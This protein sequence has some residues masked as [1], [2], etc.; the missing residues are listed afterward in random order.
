MADY[1]RP[2][3][4]R[5]PKDP[6][7]ALA[8]AQGLRDYWEPRDTRMLE[9]QRAY[10][11][12]Q[13]DLKKYEEH[14]AVNDAPIQLDKFVE[15]AARCEIHLSCATEEREDRDPA[16]RVEDAAYWALR[17]AESRHVQTLKPTFQYEA[18]HWLGLRGWLALEVLIAPNDTTGYPWRLRF[19]DPINCYPDREAGVPGLIVHEYIASHRELISHWGASTVK[20]A[21]RDGDPGPLPKDGGLTKT[22]TCWAFYTPDELGILVEGGGWLKKP[23]LHNYGTN[24]LVMVAAPGSPI[25][26]YESTT[27]DDEDTHL[28]FMGPG[29]LRTMLGPI[30][31]KARV[32]ARVMRM[33]TLTAASPWYVSTSDPELTAEDIDLEPN[34]INLGRPGDSVNPLVPPPVAFQ[35]ATGLLSMLQDQENRSGMGPQLFGEGAPGSGFD[36][37]TQ[38]GTGLSKLEIYLKTLGFWYEAVLRLMLRQFAYFGPMSLPYLAPDR[39]TGLRTA[40]NR[41]SPWDVLGAEWRLEVTFSKPNKIDFAQTA[42]VVG[43][44]IDRGVIDPETG[45][46]LLQ[47]DNPTAVIRRAMKYQ[48]YKSPE[49]VQLLSIAEWA[50]IPAENLQFL[51]AELFKAKL[52][53]FALGLK[54]TALGGTPQGMPPPPGSGL[55]SMA[56]PPAMGPGMG[57]PPGEVMLGPPQ[58]GAAP[59]LAGPP[60]GPPGLPI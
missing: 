7:E 36:R 42:N 18:L 14:V 55:P 60:V 5:I 39:T 11:L 2:E 24:P 32:A 20:K 28:K 50:G 58:V 15:E 8:L 26:R 35:Y 56:L 43:M 21:F 59:Q 49:M 45:L 30:A 22:Y 23:V 46:D 9:E 47:I 16:Q 13:Q 12:E 6:A 44:L 3:V 25:R 54:G 1:A 10:E 40:A 37:V 19:L 27:N 51:W 41:L 4:A 31:D 34:A 48:A 52:Q 38:I 33:L 17:E 57:L 29:F 53:Q